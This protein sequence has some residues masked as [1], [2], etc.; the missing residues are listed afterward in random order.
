MLA[1]AAAAAAAAA[2]LTRISCITEPFPTS[3]KV[4]KSSSDPHPI[5]DGNPIPKFEIQKIQ[6]GCF[7]SSSHSASVGCN[8][9]QA[10]Q[11]MLGLAPVSR[12]NINQKRFGTHRAAA[13]F[14]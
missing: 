12:Q 11:R 3:A 13:S 14:R 8:P 4:L 9:L 6:R 5:N 1:A 7:A 10:F 2:K